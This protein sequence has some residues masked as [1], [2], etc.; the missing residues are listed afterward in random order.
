MSVKDRHICFYFNANEREIQEKYE[1]FTEDLREF[2]VLLTN[3]LYTKENMTAIDKKTNIK[4][5]FHL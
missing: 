4:K 5:G 3:I 2:H 1:I